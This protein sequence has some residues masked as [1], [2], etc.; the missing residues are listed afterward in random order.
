MFS[1][2]RTMTSSRAC[3]GTPQSIRRTYEHRR[4]MASVM[5]AVSL[6]A[7]LA[8]RNTSKGTPGAISLIVAK[9]VPMGVSVVSVFAVSWSG[10]LMRV[11]ADSGS[12]FFVS[13]TTTLRLFVR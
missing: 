8:V 3:A 10:R 2:C 12:G 1:S 13:S 6:P 5:A 9:A 4:P 11:S 7:L